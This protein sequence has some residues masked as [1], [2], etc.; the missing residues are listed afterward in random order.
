M[1]YDL[2]FTP[3]AEGKLEI[4]VIGVSGFNHSLFVY[5]VRND[6][7]SI[8]VL[9]GRNIQKCRDA[10]LSIGVDEK[11]IIHC[12]DLQKGLEAFETGK[13]LIF[14]NVSLA[15]QMPI[16]VVVEGTGNPEASAGYALAAIENGRNV[17]AVTKESDSVVG[18]LLAKKARDKGVVYSLAEGTTGSF[19]AYVLEKKTGKNQK[20]MGSGALEGVA[21]SESANNA[22]AVGAFAP[23]LTLG[24]P[25]S[26]TTAVLLGG[27]MMWGLQPGPLLFMQQT[28][29]V[30]GLIGSMYIGNVACIIAGLITI[31]FLMSILK[32]PRGI[33][34]PMIVFVCIVGAYSVNNN[35]FDVWFMI[36]AG[37]VA[38]LLQKHKYPIAPILLA[39]VLAPRFEQAIRRAFAIS[40]GS[41]KIFIEKPISAGLLLATLIFILAPVIM[42][43]KRRYTAKSH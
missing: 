18:S 16:S 37:I 35:M 12:T 27:L 5:G 1:N 32:I 40:Q 11:D 26:G 38:F 36:G 24:I 3:E 14:D 21:A 2:L 9:C 23:L 10:Y 25:G 8:R 7:I 29:F 19:L 4:A 34:A 39:F 31:P 41:P 43:I 6:K 30:W 22:A 15:M 13:Y 33:I 42:K 17:V 20:E 28:D